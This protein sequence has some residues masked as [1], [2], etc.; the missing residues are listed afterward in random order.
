MQV[1]AV[2]LS[3]RSSIKDALK[4][5]YGCFVVTTTDFSSA[6]P[7]EGEYKLGENIADVC[8]ILKIQHVVFSTMPGIRDVTGGKAR[9]WDSKARIYNFMK[10]RDLPL[11]G[12]MISYAYSQLFDKFTFEK[13]KE[14]AFKLCKFLFQNKIKY[15]CYNSVLCK[16]DV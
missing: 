6:N 3:N 11:T 4:D 1:V 15:M 7:E 2:D 8:M 5:V 16:S 12:V 14:H 10:E 13:V 9:H